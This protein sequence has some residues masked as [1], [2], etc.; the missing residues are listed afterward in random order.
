MAWKRIV[1]GTLAQV[2]PVPC[3]AALQVFRQLSGGQCRLPAR[4]R[5][6][7]YDNRTQ[8]CAVIQHFERS[9][10]ILSRK[11]HQIISMHRVKPCGRINVNIIGQRRTVPCVILCQSARAAVRVCNS[12]FHAWFWSHKHKL[13]EKKAIIAVARKLLKLIYLLLSTN[14]VYRPPAFARR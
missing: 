2:L 6:G 4:Q 12:P 1:L 5:C 10:P 9:F 3:V 7:E 14:Q 8:G 13:G 11:K